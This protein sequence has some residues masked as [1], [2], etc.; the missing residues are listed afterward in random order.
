MIKDNK[1]GIHISGIR[2][3]HEHNLFSSSNSP[4][5]FKSIFKDIR[6]A[7]N[8]LKNQKYIFAVHQTGK[9]SV[10]SIIATGFRDRGNRPGAYICISLY[11]EKG[12]MFAKSPRA[13]LLDLIEFYKNSR[14]VF[15]ITSPLH[16]KITFSNGSHV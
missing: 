9:Y 3:G 12:M 4:N 13:Q 1:Y 7:I 10:A 14:D 16:L 5:E 11:L 2:D 15:N 8:K 6:T